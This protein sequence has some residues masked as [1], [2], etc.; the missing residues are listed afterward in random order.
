M[1]K[2]S[3]SRKKKQWGKSRCPKKR[4]TMGK[5]SLSKKKKQWGK[6]RCPKKKN[7][8]ENLVGQKKKTMG[9]ISLSKKK[10]NGENLVVQKKK[11]QRE[12][13][14]VQNQWE[15]LI[16]QKTMRKGEFLRYLD[17]GSLNSP[18]LLEVI[19][20]SEIL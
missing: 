9:K 20:F 5:I 7:N 1:G 6:S 14:V 11:K 18:R 10:I 13:L 15:N 4:E 16:I 12:N 8:G 2:I 17:L 19:I 3:L